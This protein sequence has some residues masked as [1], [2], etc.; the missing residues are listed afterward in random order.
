M[1]SLKMLQVCA[2]AEYAWAFH[3]RS[4]TVREVRASVGSM[5]KIKLKRLNYKLSWRAIMPGLQGPGENFCSARAPVGKKGEL[6][7]RKL[8]LRSYTIIKKPNATVLERDLQ[9]PL[10][11]RS[12]TDRWRRTWTQSAGRSSCF[13]FFFDRLTTWDLP[14]LLWK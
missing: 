2:R 5:S 14:F 11:T 9:Q 12:T 13:F 4:K 1:Q 8:L 6:D 10:L 7:C 3:F